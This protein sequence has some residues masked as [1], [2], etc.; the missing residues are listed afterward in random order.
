MS[1]I[2]IS[3]ERGDVDTARTLHRSF[4]DEGFS[5][6]HDEDIRAG[7]QW[8]DRLEAEIDACRNVVVLWSPTSVASRWVRSEARAGLHQRK[9]IPCMIESCRI[10]MEFSG[11][12]TIN[13]KDWSAAAPLHPGWLRIITALI[14]ERDRTSC[15]TGLSTSNP[16]I[17]GIRS[18]QRLYDLSETWYQ[19]GMMHLHGE[20][21]PRS[22]KLALRWLRQASAAGHDDARHEIARISDD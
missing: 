5:V 12:Q 17:S 22:K 3:Y 20:G 4:E 8:D 21:A 13:M 11:I 1:D 16:N 18:D 9:L 2:F 6:F 10:P 14:A 15:P 7:E 19:I